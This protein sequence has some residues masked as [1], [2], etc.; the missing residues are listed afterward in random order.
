MN[1]VLLRL[2]CLQA[3]FWSASI[4]GITLTGLVGLELSPWQRLATLPLALQVLG[5]LLA[6][7]PLS[8]LMQRRGRGFGLRLGALAGLIGA[9]ICAWALLERQFWLFCAGTLALGVYQAS[10]MFYRHCALEVVDPAKR[11]RAIALV[12]G[13][14]LCAALIAPSLVVHGRDA[15]SVPYLGAYLLIG[16][17]AVLALVIL[18]GLHAPAPPPE[19]QG[20]QTPLRTLLARRDVRL[21]LLVTASAQGLMIL[22]MNATPL[23][24]HAVHHPL[25]SSATVI[26]WHVIGMFLPAFF[27]GPLVDRFSARYMALAGALVLAASATIALS[28][29]GFT[30]FLLSS[31]ALGLGWNLL[32]VSGTALLAQ[33]HAVEERGRAQGAM[34]LTNALAALVGSAA[35]G[36]GIGTIG[37]SGINW[38]MLGLSVALLSRLVIF[39][40]SSPRTE[41]A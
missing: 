30:A 15:L 25:D 11:G 10:A 27:A 23:A 13:G 1:P 7:Q 29:E 38:L 3:L 22:V 4:A 20:A 14:G 35:A 26:Q 12:L 37:W 8:N 9:L 36:V 17:L 28:G 24:M 41:R 32:L 5:G 34:E 39:D 21:A 19:T 6:T 18:S 31:L 40:R 16:L 33:S 2:F